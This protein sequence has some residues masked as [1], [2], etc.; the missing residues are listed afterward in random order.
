M[1]LLIVGCVTAAVGLVLVLAPRIPWLP[2][3]SGKADYGVT[4]GHLPGDIHYR[5]ENSEF[6]FP[7]VSCMVVSIVL[8]TI[9]NIVI[10]LL[11]R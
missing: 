10:G 9:L 3:S 11:R 6:H 5:A 4:C 8:T 1:L 2:P 7:W